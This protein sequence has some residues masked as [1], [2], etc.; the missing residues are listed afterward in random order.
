VSGL[1]AN[2][3]IELVSNTGSTVAA[4]AGGSGT[5][6]SGTLT[7]G[8]FTVL[9]RSTAAKTKYKLSVTFYP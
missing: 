8:S 9:V 6:V 7:S 4:A 2:V 5:A 3:T 1:T